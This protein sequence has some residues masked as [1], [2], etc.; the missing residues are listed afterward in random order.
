M[1]P[2]P[3]GTCPIR[4]AHACASS[5]PRG[6]LVPADVIG[7]YPN[8]HFA[9]SDPSSTRRWKRMEQYPAGTCPIRTTSNLWRG[10]VPAEQGITSADGS[11]WSQ[12]HP[13]GACMCLII[14]KREICPC[15]RDWGLSEPSFCS[16]RTVLNPPSMG[17]DMFIPANWKRERWPKDRAVNASN[18]IL[19]YFFYRH[20]LRQA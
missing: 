19:H 17:N 11:G 8:H 4:T 16:L 10:C 1:E 14:T 15:G 13:Y 2:Y 18:Y 7:C 9:T 3:A 12:P 5:L 20:V 6:R